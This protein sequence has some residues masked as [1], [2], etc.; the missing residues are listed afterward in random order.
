[1]AS[2]SDSSGE[3][4]VAWATRVSIAQLGA[5]L[6]AYAETKAKITTFRFV[7]R[8]TNL[9]AC[10]KLPEEIISLID[11]AFKQRMKNW[12]KIERCLTYEWCNEGLNAEA[13]CADQEDLRRY[14][15]IRKTR[16]AMTLLVPL[17]LNLQF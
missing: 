5:R 1:M 7:V 4:I 15:K 14:C 12:V 3:I 8:H 9:I 13:T 2:Y 6:Y 10:R 17:H 16:T 11:I